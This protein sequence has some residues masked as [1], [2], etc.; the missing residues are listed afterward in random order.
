MEVVETMIR[1]SGLEECLG[2]CVDWWNAVFGRERFKGSA[3][4]CI[5]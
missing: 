1:V 5:G 3:L 2:G 4:I